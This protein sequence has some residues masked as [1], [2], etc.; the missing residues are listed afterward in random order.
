MFVSHLHECVHGG[1]LLW[2]HYLNFQATSVWSSQVI[3]TP[4]IKVGL[5]TALADGLYREV[6]SGHVVP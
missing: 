5:H 1:L 4:I 6:Y 3:E 2:V